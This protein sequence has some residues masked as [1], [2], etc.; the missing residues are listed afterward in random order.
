MISR[1]TFIDQSG[2][3]ALGLGALKATELASPILTSS[4]GV[5]RQGR[6]LALENSM[7]AAA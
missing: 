1:R 5:I 6:D 3:L 2:R 4:A 7:I